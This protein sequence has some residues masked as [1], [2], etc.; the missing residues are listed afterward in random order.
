MIEAIL[1]SAL[2]GLIGGLI[3][4]ISAVYTLQKKDVLREISNEQDKAQFLSDFNNKQYEL[5]R[6]LTQDFENKLHTNVVINE[7][8]DSTTATTTT[9][10]KP[11]VNNDKDDKSSTPS[12]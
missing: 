11:K 6:K 10:V 7:N 12:F 2:I 9:E 4:G 1:V 3:L 5:N 8:G